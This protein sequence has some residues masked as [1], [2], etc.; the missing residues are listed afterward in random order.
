MSSETRQANLFSAED[1]KLIYKAFQQVD[2]TA[3]DYDTIKRSMVDYIKLNFSENFNDWIEDS[4]V[5]MFIE[6]LAT[7]GGSLAFQNALNTRDNF[8]D[9]AERRDSVLRLARLISYQPKRNYC[10]SGLVKITQVATSEDIYDSAGINLASKQITWNNSNDPDW[11][12]RFILIMNAAF[13]QSNPFG[14]PVIDGFVN[15]IRTEL[16]DMKNEKA[17]FSKI[18]YPFNINISTNVTPC[19]IINATFTD[20]YNFYEK[21]PDPYA[22]F[23]IIYRNDGLGNQSKDTG[24]FL[25][26]KQGNILR[27]DFT[28]FNQIENR[29]EDINV[30]NINETDVWVHEIDGN[31][32]IINKWVFVPSIVGT[33]IIYNSIVKNKRNIFSVLTRDNDQITIRYADGNFGNVPRGIFR[34]WHRSSNGLSYTIKPSDIS[35]FKVTIPYINSKGI[36]HF[37]R[38][39]YSLQ[40]SVTNS[41][42]RET[43]AQ[44]KLRAPQAYYLQNRM[45]NGEDYNIFPLITNQAVKVKAINRVYSGHNRYI[46]I[47]D[48]TGFSQK[49]NI[50][51]NDGIIFREF[52]VNYSQQSIPTSNTNDEIITFNIKSLIKNVETQNF[53]YWYLNSNTNKF[54]RTDSTKSN[55]IPTVLD[56][57][58]LT[59]QTTIKWQKRSNSLYSSTGSIYANETNISVGKTGSGPLQYISI[60]A[61]IKFNK[62][63]WATVKGLLGDG[64]YIGNGI[65]INNPLG[66][67]TLDQDVDNGDTIDYVIPAYFPDINSSVFAQIKIQ[68]QQKNTFGL[69]FDFVNQNWV[70]IDS[71]NIN[72]NGEYSLEFSGDI[73]R[74]SKDSSWLIKCVYKSTQWEFSARAL[75]YVFESYNDVRFFY[76]NKYKTIDSKTLQ[77][78][79]DVVN[80]LQYNNKP[81]SNNM[82]GK[83][84]KFFLYDSYS[85]KDGYLEPRRV[86]VTPIDSD[87]DGVSDNPLAFDEI[88]FP[89][90]L[91]TP[92][93][94]INVP[95]PYMNTL[96]SN[97]D[98]LVFWTKYTDKDNYDYYVPLIKD[99]DVLNKNKQNVFLT[100]NVVYFDMNEL[101]FY[102][103]NGDQF[104]L[105]ADQSKYIYKE[106][107]GMTWSYANADINALNFQWKHFAPIDQRIDPAPTNIIDIFVLTTDYYNSIT[108]WAN[109]IVKLVSLPDPPTSEELRLTF[110]NITPYAM[111]SDEIIWR[112][113]R[114]KFLFGDG[115]D[116]NLRATFQV[117]KLSSATMSDGEVKS[118]IIKAINEYFNINEWDFGETFYFIE[119]ATYIQRKLTGI[120]SS[121]VPVP[122]NSNSKFGNLFQ[123]KADPDE[124][125]FSLA[126]VADINI[127]SNYSETILKVGS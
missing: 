14:R 102:T 100:T 122:S 55:Y 111:L 98:Y 2:F 65:D 108:S 4:E 17:G 50:F 23:S 103:Y 91:D 28:Y 42:P 112:P 41:N 88:V 67:I 85:Y 116:L 59:K 52:D 40:Y 13:V 15:N 1:W 68:M 90:R 107:R 49:T 84:I 109:Q 34:V 92:W 47:N 24:F 117:V 75:R 83:D 31:G 71:G 37:L 120:I 101:M 61:M 30:N 87:D 93:N 53:F 26:F 89:E 69:R 64:T 11:F 74:R 39:E 106:G 70:L 121:I 3:Y 79:R 10:A 25:M 99:K 36:K 38:M 96:Y 97:W 20:G 86:K 76:I 51:S 32:I 45:V 8:I 118:K 29:T 105:I 123:I 115:A 77:Q 19:E 44:I 95:A 5:V 35:G 94:V 127:V 125:F 21:E 62:S 110:T 46:D 54:G 126:S 33:N 16:Y 113:V 27:K 9:T 18:N 6:L 60:G 56:F 81:N 114:F 124:L 43:L 66:P 7:L 12:E 72:L 73:S 63:G 104:E 58:Y 80:I 48:P 119:M 82:I 78:S 22:A 57:C